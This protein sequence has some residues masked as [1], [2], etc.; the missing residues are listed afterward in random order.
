MGDGI[1]GEIALAEG[2][3]F[4]LSKNRVNDESG[5]ETVSRGVRTYRPYAKHDALIPRL[6]GIGFY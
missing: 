6:V 5:M 4:E 1:F 2:E 3:V